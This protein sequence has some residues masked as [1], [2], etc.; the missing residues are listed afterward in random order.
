MPS[1][2]LFN[3]EFYNTMANDSRMV[4]YLTDKQV[5]EQTHWM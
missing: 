2:P 1:I 5:I 3:S 4:K